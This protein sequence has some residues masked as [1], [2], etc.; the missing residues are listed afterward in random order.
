ML[1]QERRRRGKLY[2]GAR[3]MTRAHM[4]YHLGTMFLAT[5]RALNN[6]SYRCAGNSY[7]QEIVLGVLR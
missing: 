3:A 4:L 2:T 7:I 5:T 1:R 6:L